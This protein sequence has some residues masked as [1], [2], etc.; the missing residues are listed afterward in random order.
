MGRIG[1]E[2]NQQMSEPERKNM[3]RQGAKGRTVH[4]VGG[5]ELDPIDRAEHDLSFVEKRT[6]AMLILLRGTTSGASFPSMRIDA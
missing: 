6:D 5:L 1:A 3:L 2:D 4:D